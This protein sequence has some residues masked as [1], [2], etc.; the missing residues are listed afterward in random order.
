MS[1]VVRNAS[2]FALVVGVCASFFLTGCDGDYRPRATGKEGEVTVVMD[3][4]HWTGPVGDT[5]RE[6]VTPWV[7]T[8]P[9][10]ERFFEIRHLELSTERVYDNIQD[11]KNVVVVAPLSDSTN[12][13]DF[14]RRRLSEEAQQAVKDGQT[15]VVSKPNLWRRSQR[16]YFVTAATPEDLVSALNEGGSDIRSTFKEITLERMNRDMYDDA[17]QYALEDSLMNRHDFAV[18][19]QH[20]FQVAVDTATASTGFVWL[21]RILA[22]TRREFFVYYED[23]MS[24]EDITTEW[25]YETRDSLTRQYLQGNVSGFARIDYRRPLETEQ[26]EFKDR[27]GYESQG[28]W[29]MVTASEDSDQ[30][31]GVGGGGPFVTY[32]FYDQATDRVYLLDGSVFAPEHE[33][34]EFLRQME[35]MAHTFRT[36]EESAR[37]D[38][39]VAASQ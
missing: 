23:G 28:L 36:R 20:D 32:A 17:R 29:H 31:Q 21:R 12:E 6:T 13:A 39:S 34:L 37:G 19:V 2:V 5:F 8:L 11:L 15:A 7:N 27:Y 18:N 10:P 4:S 30:F 35:V 16:V 22:K 9:Q 26:T 33:K 3:S 25:I 38:S 1:R 24:P 14:L